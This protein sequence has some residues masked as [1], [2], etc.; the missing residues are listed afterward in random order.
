MRFMTVASPL[1]DQ[2][3]SG[4]PSLEGGP[5]GKRPWALDPDHPRLAWVEAIFMRFLAPFGKQF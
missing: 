4:L 2:T 3:A 1:M 5:A